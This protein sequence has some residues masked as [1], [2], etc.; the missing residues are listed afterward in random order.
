MPGV[1]IYMLGVWYI[2]VCTWACVWL[3]SWVCVCENEYEHMSVC[4]HYIACSC[5]SSERQRQHSIQH[6]VPVSKRK[7]VHQCSLSRWCAS[8][9]AGGKYSGDKHI[10]Q[11]QLYVCGVC[12]HARNRWY[13]LLRWW[14]TWLPPCTIMSVPRVACFAANLYS[15]FDF[16]FLCFYST[17]KIIIATSFVVHVRKTHRSVNESM[18]QCDERK[19][20]LQHHIDTTAKQY[21]LPSHRSKWQRPRAWVITCRYSTSLN[22]ILRPARVF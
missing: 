5:S 13:H 10:G 12:G 16:C 7:A 20:R 15:F 6:S 3:Y 2:G 1:W 21:P 8:M 22:A 11:I 14:S 17:R 9:R 18:S 19:T 4:V